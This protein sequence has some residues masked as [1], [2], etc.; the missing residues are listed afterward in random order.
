VDRVA[1]YQAAQM[2]ESCCMEMSLVVLQN[3][4]LEFQ[5]LQMV[6]IDSPKEAQERV[7]AT[8]VIGFIQ[9]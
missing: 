4:A 5:A 3:P 6:V 7:E 1:E 2:L 8:R 9:P